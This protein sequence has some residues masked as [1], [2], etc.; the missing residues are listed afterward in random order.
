MPCTTGMRGCRR[1]CLHRRLVDGYRDA[2]DARD[3]LRESDA[4]APV[5]VTGTNGAHV[6]MAQL[7]DEEFARHVPP[8]LFKD[9]LIEHK[10]PRE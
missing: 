4:P 5:G 9:W 2:R 8:V 3:A 10:R 7:E 6:S 1:D